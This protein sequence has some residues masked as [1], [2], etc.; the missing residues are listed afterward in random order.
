MVRPTGRLAFHS[1]HHPRIGCRSQHRGMSLCPL[2]MKVRWGL[3]PRVLSPPPYRTLTA[4]LART[5]VSIGLEVN[6]LPSPEPPRLD[7]WF[8]RAGRDSAFCS[9]AFFSRRCIRSWESR[10]WPLSRPKAARLTPPS[11]LL[12]TAG[13]PGGTRAFPRTERAVAVHLCPR[14]AATSTDLGLMQELRTASP[15]WD[16]GS[17]ARMPQNAPPSVPSSPTPLHCT[18]TGT[19]IAPL[20]PLAQ[21]LEAWLTPP[22]L[23]RWLMC[24]IWLGYAIQFIRRSPKFNA[25]LETSM[26]VQNAPVLSEEIAVLLAKDIIEPVPSAEM[27][28]PSWVLPLPAVFF[29]DRGLPIPGPGFPN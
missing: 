28:P 3:P 12:S 22:S 7:D 18:T 9:G 27:S 16:P 11:S 6:R 5:A 21:R 1:V 2:R 23:S 19:S 20:E 24:T 15:V 10:G 8:L 25:V 29:P 4:M 17:S 13:L 26:A 14:N